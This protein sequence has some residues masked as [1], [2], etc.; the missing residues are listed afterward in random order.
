MIPFPRQ[1]VLVEYRAVMTDTLDPLGCFD[2]T[3][4]TD[5]HRTAHSRLERCVDRDV[6]MF[7][8]KP[9]RKLCHRL[10][11]GSWSTNADLVTPVVVFRHKV[12]DESVVASGSV[13]G[14]DQVRRV[15]V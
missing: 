3:R 4:I 15:W 7:L 6:P 12:G 1:V 10:H 2:D 8:G 14:G 9:R 13:I 11:H 5:T